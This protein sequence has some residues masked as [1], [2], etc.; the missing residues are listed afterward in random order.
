MATTLLSSSSA[1]FPTTGATC[2][3][4][5]LSFSCI[6]IFS[7]YDIHLVHP[8]VSFT[9]FFFVV[10]RLHSRVSFAGL[11]QSHSFVGFISLFAVDLDL[12]NL[13]NPD[14]RTAG[15][16]TGYSHK[17]N[18]DSQ[19]VTILSLK[20]FKIMHQNSTIEDMATHGGMM[21]WQGMTWQ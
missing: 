2:S 16:T 15:E 8:R 11:L 3:R 6:G 10:V 20:G 13:A 21:T 19:L 18:H 17:G 9:T 4:L 12:A 14:K 7:T 5:Y 1:L